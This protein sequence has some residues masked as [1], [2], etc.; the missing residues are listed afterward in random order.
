[1]STPDFSSPPVPPGL[2]DVA[3]LARL[4]GEFFSE[5]PGGGKSPTPPFGPGTSSPALGGVM[6]SA[7]GIGMPFW[8]NAVSNLGS[9]GSLVWRRFR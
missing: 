1:M 2:P 7:F 8:A 9:V 5:L 6:I 3:T 4:A